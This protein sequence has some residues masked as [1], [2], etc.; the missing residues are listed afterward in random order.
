[1]TSYIIRVFVVVFIIILAALFLHFIVHPIWRPSADHLPMQLMIGAP[2]G[3]K[4]IPGKKGV[5]G[6][7]DGGSAT[8]CGSGTAIGG[9]GGRGMSSGGDPRGGEG[10]AGGLG[11]GGPGGSGGGA[12]GSSR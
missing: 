5:N 1:M 10:G 3:C 6:G 4:T 12:G 11:L 8:V 9:E 2:V 7:G